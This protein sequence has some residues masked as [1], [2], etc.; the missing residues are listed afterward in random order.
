MVFST[1]ESGIFLNPEKLKQSEQ[2]NQSNDS[3]I[4]LFTP[5]KKKELKY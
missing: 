2:S 1:F 4:S 5:K 3:D